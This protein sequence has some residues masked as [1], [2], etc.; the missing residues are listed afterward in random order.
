MQPKQVWLKDGKLQTYTN[1][2]EEVNVGP[3]PTPPTPVV[4]VTGVSVEPTSYQ[5]Q[6]GENFYVEATVS[7]EDAT[8]QNVTWSSSDENVATVTQEGYV[9]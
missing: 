6:Y 7:P 3:G 4:P 9:E 8:N 1:H 2:W 5:I